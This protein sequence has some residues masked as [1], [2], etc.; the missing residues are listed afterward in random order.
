MKENQVLASEYAEKINNYVNNWKINSC[1]P[2]QIKCEKEEE[3]IEITNK[4]EFGSADDTM[5]NFY[6]GNGCDG[7]SVWFKKGDDIQEVY[8]EAL[9][10]VMENMKERVKDDI[11]NEID[12]DVARA[13][14]E[15]DSEYE[16]WYDLDVNREYYLHLVIDIYN[17]SWHATILKSN[18]YERNDDVLLEK[19]FYDE[20][21][22]VL[23]EKVAQW[24]AERYVE[25]K[26]KEETINA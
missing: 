21:P 2:L 24:A 18:L 11:M 5:F 3:I 15:G 10:K 26:M 6:V 22:V 1:L 8:K 7:G 25:L 16:N 23:M 17:N 4:T 14:W 12:W 19:S 9:S 20:A 13:W